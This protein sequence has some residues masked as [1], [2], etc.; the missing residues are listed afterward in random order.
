MRQP[1]PKEMK[2]TTAP[3]LCNEN[4]AQISSARALHVFNEYRALA[5]EHQRGRWKETFHDARAFRRVRSPPTR[6]H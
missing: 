4:I 1:Y 5:A 3:F 6:K 2:L